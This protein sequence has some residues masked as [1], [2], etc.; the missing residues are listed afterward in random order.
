MMNI[1]YLLENK[2][3]LKMAYIIGVM[4]ERQTTPLGVMVDGNYTDN[5]EDMAEKWFNDLIK[6][7]DKSH[8]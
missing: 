4:H 3:E 8:D 5:P 7:I 2:D 1:S 6:N